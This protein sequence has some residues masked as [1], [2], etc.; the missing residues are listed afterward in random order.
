MLSKGALEIFRGPLNPKFLATVGEDGRPNVV[1]IISIT[2]PTDDHLAFGEFMIWKT[3][4]NLLNNN[5]I[6]IYA[7][8]QKL[9]ATAGR[10]LFKGFVKTGPEVDYINNMDLFRYNA[11]TGIRSAGIIQ[12][13]SEFPTFRIPVVSSLTGMGLL[14]AGKTL[15]KLTT[16]KSEIEIPEAVR[17]KFDKPLGFKVISFVE[18]DGFPIIFLTM[19]MKLVGDYL[20]F[21]INSQN[22]KIKK[23][24]EGSPVAVNILTLEPASYQLKGIYEGYSRW[25][26]TPVG[27]IRVTE[28]YSASPP[29]PGKLISSASSQ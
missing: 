15:F 18:E 26:T 6:Y 23:F 11:Y 27:K 24:S 28:V 4:K 8:T 5:K 3:K 29:V 25:G 19:A 22:K 9:K 17:E 13:L 7:F 14:Q 21:P 10:A 16:G 20:I 1:L 12:P 2:A